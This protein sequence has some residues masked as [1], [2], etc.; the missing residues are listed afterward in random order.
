MPVVG[1]LELGA[2]I[3]VGVVGGCGSDGAAGGGGSAG[4]GGA[5]GDGGAGGSI[6]PLL[7]EYVLS[8][9]TLV[10]ES[11]AFDLT[12]RS[13]YVGSETKGNI[14]QVG[15]DGTESIFMTPRSEEHTS[16]LQSH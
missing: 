6:A 10:P 1:L 11:G 12:S 5:G 2:L 4:A 13:F 15:A 16:E 9:E 7:D 3:L 14:T 8:D